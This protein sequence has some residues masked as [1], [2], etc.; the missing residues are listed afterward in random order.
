MA[1]CLR[2][3]MHQLKINERINF[4]CLN[5]K[6][7]STKCYNNTVEAWRCSS[8]DID[9]GNLEKEKKGVYYECSNYCLNVKRVTST[10]NENNESATY[11]VNNQ[12]P[13]KEVYMHGLRRRNK[14]AD[15]YRKW[16]E[17]N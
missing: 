3:T 1:P 11:L 16:L 13:Y 6:Y 4:N 17:N 14:I 7:N 2:N 10:N 8:N 15:K 12:T 5:A 9:S